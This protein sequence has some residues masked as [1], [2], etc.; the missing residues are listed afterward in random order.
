MNYFTACSDKLFFLKDFF[1]HP[2]IPRC[3]KLAMSIEHSPSLLVDIRTS[4]LTILLRHAIQ[5]VPFYQEYAKRKGWT[6]ATVLRLEDFPVLQ[7][8]DFRGCE[9][10][11][12]SNCACRPRLVACRTSGSTGEP[13]RFYQ[14]KRAFAYT[15]ATFW[16]GLLRYGIR[17]GDKR[18]L[19]K[20][21]DERISF[22]VIQKFRRIMYGYF[23]RCLVID[24]HF[25]ARSETNMFNVVRAI[26]AYK[27]VYFHGYVSSIYQIARFIAEHS[28][29]ISQ[30][31]LKGIVTESEKLHDFQRNMIANVF[32]C[33]VVE[34]YGSVEFGL[35]AQPD[36]KG[37]HCIN[38][39]HCVVEVNETGE[40]I[41]TNLDESGFPFIRFK[42]GDNV[43]LEQKKRSALPYTEIETIE[44]RVADT[45]YLPGGGAIQG[46]IV[47]YPISKHMEYIREYQIRQ[48]KIDTLRILIVESKPLPEKIMV[49]I[50]QEMK[51]IVGG[52]VAVN[53]SFVS[54]IPLT[55]R[56]KRRFVV[57]LLP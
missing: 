7:K 38:D 1:R 46:F 30:L 53:I 43:K 16:R 54:N 51:E 25:L 50:I 31:K 20:G 22:S 10:L 27:P 4:K 48:E 28:I 32:N 8:S 35:I 36:E 13:F 5:T 14:S 47:M 33:P 9:H 15:Y 21:V 49:Q 24:A 40:G 2:D 37:V 39:D 17:P 42:N 45:L 52:E 56:G 12:V 18:V 44:G 34:N 29:E 23:N 26:C 11:F 57:S 19:V 55:S 41:F 6:D 3:F